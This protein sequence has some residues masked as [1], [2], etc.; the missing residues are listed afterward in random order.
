MLYIWT[1]YQRWCG[2]GWLY[3]LGVLRMLGIAARMNGLAAPAWSQRL[4]YCA[5]LTQQ[6]ARRKVT[7]HSGM[8]QDAAI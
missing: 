4:A 2:A 6:L 7:Q 5:R 3:S 1:V 8:G